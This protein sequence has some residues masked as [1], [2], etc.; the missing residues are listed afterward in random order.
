M[1]PAASP[2]ARSS[3]WRVAA[4]RLRPAGSQLGAERVTRR[5]LAWIA[6]NHFEASY[7]QLGDL[8][9]VF[10]PEFEGCPVGES[11]EGL[12]LTLCGGKIFATDAVE[13]SYGPPRWEPLRT[14]QSA[15]KRHR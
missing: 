9:T 10:L 1:R 3:L 15:L 6:V 11:A 5:A 2:I 13:L 4:E 8:G 12:V 7:E 14:A